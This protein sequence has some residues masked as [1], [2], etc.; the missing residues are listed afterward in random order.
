MD[1]WREIEKADRERVVGENVGLNYS[2]LVCAMHQKRG[3]Q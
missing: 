3:K 1:G 2:L